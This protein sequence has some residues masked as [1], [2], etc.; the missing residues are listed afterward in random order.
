MVGLMEDKIVL[1][2]DALRKRNEEIA[3]LKEKIEASD[4]AYR[5]LLR[6]NKSM[7]KRLASWKEK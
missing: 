7:R 1:L 3:E 6:E 5:E 4:R 2:E